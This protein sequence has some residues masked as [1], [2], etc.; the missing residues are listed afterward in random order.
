MN[1][2]APAG[3]AQNTCSKTHQ[4]PQVTI[5]PLI[6]LAVQVPQIIP[7][8]QVTQDLQV[9]HV[10]QQHNLIPSHQI[11]ILVLPVHNIN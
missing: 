5:K 6:P 4:A 7:E 1:H 9:T 3:P 8:P 2:G 11:T 10:S